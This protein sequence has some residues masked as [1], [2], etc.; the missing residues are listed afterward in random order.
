MKS[1]SQVSISRLAALALAAGLSFILGLSGSGLSIVGAASDPITIGVVHDLT[2]FLTQQGTE[3]NAGIR[4]HMD[5]IGYKVA[6][7]EIKLLFEDSE[8]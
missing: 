6:G 1:R 4:L 7:R 2:G 5:E 8:T 3:I